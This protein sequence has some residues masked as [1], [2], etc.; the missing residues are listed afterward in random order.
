MCDADNKRVTDTDKVI[1]HLYPRI[2]LI[3]I[4][5]NTTKG[6]KNANTFVPHVTKM[7]KNLKLSKNTYVQVVILFFWL[8]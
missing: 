8:S 5:Q 4:F 6:K 1:C 3:C 7:R 2:H